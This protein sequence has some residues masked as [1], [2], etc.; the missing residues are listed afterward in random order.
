MNSGHIGEKSVFNHFRQ[1]QNGKAEKEISVLVILFWYCKMKMFTISGSDGNGYVQSVKL[2][3][4]KTR[5]SD[6]D[7]RILERPLSKIVKFVEQECVRFPNNEAQEE[8]ISARY[9]G[10]LGEAMCWCTMVECTLNRLMM[11]N[12][13]ILFFILCLF[14]WSLEKILFA[15]SPLSVCINR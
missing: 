1:M 9:L 4:G 3:I 14:V 15:T 13:W 11:E 8:W 10:Y 2:K 12:W 5:N 7:D 6:G